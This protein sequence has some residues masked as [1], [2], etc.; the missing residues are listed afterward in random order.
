M[1]LKADVTSESQVRYLFSTVVRTLGPITALVN[2]AG[3]SVKKSKGAAIS[4]RR[5]DS[6][7][8][9]NLRAPFFCLREAAKYLPMNEAAPNRAIVNVSSLSVQS[10][11]GSY[12]IDYAAAKAGVEAMTRG[13]AR[14]LV[15]A[16]IRV[17]AVSPG[18]TNTDMAKCFSDEDIVRIKRRIGLKR[19]AT[20]K[21]IAECIVFLLSSRASYIT[22]LIFPV[23]GGR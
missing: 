4:K 19:F 5:F 3:A 23:H 11:G 6:T 17:N 1:P 21:E 7:I 20:P 12:H 2:N 22:G 8:S 15:D 14:E 10:G 9:A 16:G 13:F 18:T